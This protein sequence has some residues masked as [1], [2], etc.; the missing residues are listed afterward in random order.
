MH[1]YCHTFFSPFTPGIRHCLIITF[2]L[3]LSFPS[4]FTYNYNRHFVFLH[5]FFQDF[6]FAS[7]IQGSYIPRSNL[8]AVLFLLISVVIV[9]AVVPTAG[10]RLL[11]YDL[12]PAQALFALRFKSLVKA[13][14]PASEEL[15]SKFPSSRYL[16][17]PGSYPLG[18]YG[19]GDPAGSNATFG[20]ALMFTGTHKPL[21]HDKM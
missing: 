13:L 1:F 5:L 18:L 6:E 10:S 2:Y 3:T 4:H 12:E 8:V 20:L 11:P 19:L 7:S 21:R 16:S 15:L 14:L 17:S 9:L